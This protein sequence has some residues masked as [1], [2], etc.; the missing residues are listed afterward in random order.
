MTGPVP[1]WRTTV[2][3]PHEKFY[4]CVHSDLSYLVEIVSS[5]ASCDIFY[6][7]EK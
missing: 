7:Q 3:S 4:Y 5:L 1:A 2:A 6:R